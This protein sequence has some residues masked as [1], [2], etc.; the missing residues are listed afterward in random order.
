M[1]DWSSN[2]RTDSLAHSFT[3]HLKNV[4]NIIS[5]LKLSLCSVSTRLSSQRSS[6]SLFLHHPPKDI[7]HASIFP[8]IH[9]L[10]HL[11]FDLHILFVLCVQFLVFCICWFACS[12][13]SLKWN[14]EC[15]TKSHSITQ[16][17]VKSKYYSNQYFSQ[18]F[19]F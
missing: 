4:P 5:H 11:S 10:T 14:L 19:L 18:V 15:T 17:Y 1:T 2:R 9:A 13:W 6:V 8:L 12:V 7:I 16:Y 3:H